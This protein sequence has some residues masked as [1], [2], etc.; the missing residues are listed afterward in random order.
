MGGWGLFNCDLFEGRGKNT[1]KKKEG[2]K[3]KGARVMRVCWGEVGVV[4]ILH[5]VFGMCF[6]TD[7]H[8][9]GG[10]T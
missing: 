10:S 1:E 5:R 9:Q 4:D 6:D 3:S 8:A 7:L 2:K